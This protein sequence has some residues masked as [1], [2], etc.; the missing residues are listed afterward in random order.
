MSSVEIVKLIAGQFEGGFQRTATGAV[1]QDLRYRA[2]FST[3]NSALSFGVMQ[4]DIG[5]HGGAGDQAFRKILG[6]ATAAGALTNV[7]ADTL[8]KKAAVPGANGTNL[9]ASEKAQLDTI[10]GASYAKPVIDQFDN[11]EAAK[12]WQRLETGSEQWSSAWTSRGYTVLAA[13]SPADPGYYDLL[14][15]VAATLNKRPS[16][17]DDIDRL[18]S[19][20]PLTL[21][22]GKTLQLTRPPTADDLYAAFDQL[23]V[24]NGSRGGVNGKIENLRERLQPVPN[25]IRLE[26]LGT[27]RR[28]GALLFDPSGTGPGYAFDATSPASWIMT[29][30]GGGATAQRLLLIDGQLYVADGASGFPRLFG[31]S[32]DILREIAVTGPDW[33]V[34]NGYSLDYDFASSELVAVPATPTIALTSTGSR[35]SIKI[36]PGREGGSLVSPIYDPT[37][38]VALPKGVFLKDGVLS[39]AS[40]RFVQLDVAPDLN[41]DHVAV[42]HAFSGNGKLEVATTLAADGSVVD[43]KVGLTAVGETS[44]MSFGSGGAAIGSILGSY[45]AGDNQIAAIAS[46]VITAQV[47]QAI[48]TSLGGVFAG[49][50][51]SQA[52]KTAAT[53][54]P[55]DLAVAGIGAVSS[56]LTAELIHAVGLNGVAAELANTV[57]SVV[58]TQIVTN[59]VTKGAAN[60]FDAL[61]GTALATA[62]GSY[63]GNKLASALVKFDTIGGQLGSAIGSSVAVIAGLAILG[64]PAGWTA[65]AVAAAASFIGNLFGGPI[66]SIFGGTPR[67]GADVTWDPET[68]TFAATN[69]WSRKGGSQDAARG[70]AASVAAT[71]NNILGTIGGTLLN[72]TAVQ[73]GNY[74]LRKSEYVYRPV[75]SQDTS[76]ITR[77]FKGKNGSSDLINYG[78]GQALAGTGFAIAGG[79]VI[80]KRALYASTAL[81]GSGFAVD[82]LLGDLATAQHYETYLAN[83]TAI[84]ALISAEPG[85]VFTAEQAIILARAVELGLTRRAASDWFGGFGFLLN[86]LATVPSLADFRFEFDPASGRIAR[87]ID[88]G[89]YTMGDTIDVAGQTVIQGTAGNDDIRLTA[90]QLAATNAGANINVGLIVDDV[91]FNGAAKDLLVAAIVDAGAGDDRVQASDRGDNVFGGAGNDTLLGGKLDDWLIGGDGNDRL[92]AGTVTTTAF[93]DGALPAINSVIASDGGSGNYLDGGVG[94]DRLYGGSGS[95]WL[96][97]G[98]NVDL[99]YGGAGGDIIDGGTGNDQ[100]SALN[101]PALFGG[102]GSDQYVYNRGDGSD[103]IFDSANPAAAAGDNDTLSISGDSIAKRLADIQGGASRNWAGGGDF[104]IDGSVTGGEDAIV[105]GTGITMADILLE[106]GGDQTNGANN[107]LKIKVLDPVTG[108]WNLTDQILVRDWFESTRR[109]EWLRFANGDELRIGDLTTFKIGTAAADVLIG[110]N[111]ADFLYG[112][113]GDDV[114][115]GLKG[116]DFGDGGLGD[117]LVS[118]DDD[119]DIVLGGQGK[120]IVLGGKG[121]DV[122]S[123]DAGDDKLYGGDGGDVVVGGKGDDELIGGAGDDIFKIDRGDG[124]DLLFDELASGWELVWNGDYTNGYAQQTDGTVAKGGV[125]YFDGKTW[126]GRYNYDQGQGSA[127]TIRELYRYVGSGA[128]VNAGSDTLEFGVGID[129]QDLL[130]RKNGNDLEIA[131]TPSGAATD[132][133][134]AVANRVTIQD[135]Y[136]APTI[137][138]FQFVATGALSVASNGQALIQLVAGTDADDSALSATGNTSGAWITGGGGADTISG[139]GQYD[140]LNGGSGSDAL[141]AGAGLDVLYGG[142]GN[143]TLDGGAGAD[144]L[145]GGSGSDTASYASSTAGLTVFI[146]EALRAYRSKDAQD[147]AYTGIENLM[148]SGYADALY[149]DSGDNVLD[150]GTGADTLYGGEGDDSY[151]L[152]FGTG[153]DTIIEGKALPDFV[154]DKDGKID[155][156]RYTPV[157]SLAGIQSG[158]YQYQLR[159]A[160][161]SDGLVAYDTGKVLDSATVYKYNAAKPV[162]PYFSNGVWDTTVAGFTDTSWKSGYARAPN[163]KSVLAT[164]ILGNGGALDVLEIGTDNS[165]VPRGL[166]LSNLSASKAGNSLTIV[167][168]ASDKA[169]IQ[170]FYLSDDN[171]VET[172]QF[173]DGLAVDLTK[174]RLGLAVDSGT[175]GDDLIF[176]TS[177]ADSL[178]GNLGNDVLS[179]GVGADTLSGGAGDDVL[180]GGGQADALDGGSDTETDGGLLD[181]AKPYGDTIRYVGSSALVNVDL[182][183]A[184]AQIGGDAAGDLI[185]FASGVS[186]IENITG[187]DGYGDTLTGDAR[188]NRLFGLGGNDSIVGGGGDDV[189]A[190]GVGNDTL[191]GEAGNDNISGDDGDDTIDGGSGNDVIA[192]GLGL[193]AIAGGTG[194][195]TI[196]GGNDNDTSLHGNDGNDG[197]GGGAGNDAVFGDAGNDQLDGGSGNDTLWGGLDNDTL[198]G[199]AGDDVLYGEAGDDAYA[200]D[201]NSGSDTIVDAAGANRIL[202]SSVAYD[203]LWLVKSGNDLRISVIGGSSSVTV[204]DYFAVTS[205]TLVRE[206]ATATHSLF[207]KYAGGQSYAGSLIEAM[208]LAGASAPAAMPAAIAARLG[209]FWWAGGKA[210]PAVM[211]QALNVAEDAALVGQVGAVDHDENIASYTLVTPPLHGGAPVIAANG[212]WSYTPTAN[213]NGPDSFQIKVRDADGNEALQ[214]VNV[215]VTPVNDLP[216]ITTA[217]NALAVDENAA[218]NSVIGTLAVTDV[219]GDLLAWSLTDDAGGRFL[220]SSAGVLSVRDGSLLNRETAVSHSITVQVS[221]GVGAPVAKTM[222]IG[223]NDVNERPGT[224]LQTGQP[225]VRANESFGGVSAALAGKTVATLSVSD[226]DAGQTPVLRL[227]AGD[228][229]VFAISGGNL[230]FASGFNPDFE[231]LALLPGTTLVDRD[232]N[233]RKEVELTASVGGFDGTLASLGTVSVTVGI[234]DVNEAPTAIALAGSLT[235]AERDH[236]AAGDPLLAA[237]LGT[238]STTDPDL[239]SLEGFAYT[240]SDSAAGDMFEVSGN[241]LRLKAG[242]SLDYET[243]A[244]DGTNRYVD[245]TVTS[246]DRN[247][248]TGSLAYAKTFHVLLSDQ[249]D[250]TYGTSGNDAGATKLVGAAGADVIFGYVGADQLYGGNGNDD[251][252]G[253]DGN[254]YLYGENGDDTVRGEAGNDWLYGS[255]GDDQLFGG[256]GDDIVQGDAGN[257]TMSGDDG[258][259]TLKG[260]TGN[261]TL[262]GGAGNDLLYGGSG[263]NT[264]GGGDG[265][266]LL[267]GGVNGDAFD[268]GLGSDT[269]SYAWTDL[270]IAATTGVTVNVTAPGSNLGVA[271]GDSYTAIERIDATDFADT[272]TGSAASETLNGLGDID[273]IDGGGGDDVIDGG[274]GND[275]LRGSSGNDSIFGSTGLDTLYGDAGFDTLDGGD[276]ND[277]LHGGD[278]GDVLKGGLGNDTLYGEG[279][280]DIFSFARGDGD[281]VVDQTGALAGDIDVLGFTGGIANTNLWFET[282]GRDVKVSVLGASGYDGSVRLKDH[283]DLS[284]HLTKVSYVTAGK[285]VTVDLGIQALAATLDQFAAALGYK[286]STQSQFDALMANTTLLVAGKTFKQHWDNYWTG[287]K[288]PAFTLTNAPAFSAGWAEDQYSGSGFALS[289][290][291]ADDLTA[292]PSLQ[293]TAMLVTGNGSTTPTAA[294]LGG[295]TAAWPTDGTSTGTITLKTNANTSGSGWLWLHAVDAGGVEANEWLPF[296][297]TAVA[298]APLITAAA[299]PGGNAGA[300][301][302]LNI[303]ALLT[304]TDGSEVIDRIEISG[305]PAGFDFASADH[306]VSAGNNALG[307]A[308][309]RFSTAQLSGLTLTAPAG[310]SADLTGAAALQVRAFSV[311][312][313]NGSQAASSSSTPLAVRINAPPTDVVFTGSVDENAAPGTVI[314]VVTVTDPDGTE[315][316]RLDLTPWS[317]NAALTTAGWKLN[318]S[319]ETQ[320]FATTGPLGGTVTALRTGQFD[321]GVAGGGVE[322]SAKVTIDPN[323]AYKFSV[324]FRAE[325]LTK[326]TL[327]FGLSGGSPAYV[328]NGGTGAD[329]GNPY[330]FGI[331]PPQEQALFQTGVWY[332]ADGVVLPRGHQL[333]GNG[334]FGGIFNAATGVRLSNADTQVYRWNDTMPDTQVATRFFSYYNE[335]QSGWSHDWY[336]PTITE[337]PSLTLADTRG[338]RLAIDSRSGLI[339]VGSTAIDYEDT[340]QLPAGDKAFHPQ[341]T[342]TDSGGL[343]LTKAINVTVNNVNELPFAPTGPAQAY[344]DETWL[345]SNPA[346][347]GTVLASFALADPDGTTPVLTFNDSA[348]SNGWYDLSGGQVRL[349][350]GVSF[351]FEWFKANGSTFRDFNSDGREEVLVD[352]F[353]LRAKDATDLSAASTRFQLFIQNTNETPNAPGL[354]TYTP[355]FAETLSGDTAHANQTIATFALSDPDQVTPKLELLTNPNGWFSTVGNALVFSG[356]VNF[357]ADWMRTYSGPYGGG[358]DL[359]GDGLYESKVSTVLV[360]AKDTSGLISGGVPVDVYIEDVNERPSFGSPSYGAS[361]AENAAPQ[362]IATVT[363]IDPDQG[364]TGSKQFYFV[365]AGGSTVGSIDGTF[366]VAGTTADGRFAIDAASGAIRSTV[367]FDY[368]TNPG[369]FDYTVLTRDATSSPRVATAPLHVSPQDVNEAPSIAPGQSFSVA[370]NALG[371][372]STLVGTL[373]AND[374]DTAAAN[375]NLKYAITSG[376]TGNMFLI[377]SAGEIRLNASP[378]YE[379]QTSYTLGVSVIDQGG[380][381]LSA[382][383]A[384]T[385]TINPVNEAPKLST[386]ISVMTTSNSYATQLLGSVAASDPEGDV[387]SVTKTGNS[388][389]DFIRVNASGQ[390][391]VAYKPYSYY[392][393]S[394]SFTVT[395]R[396]TSTPEHYQTTNTINWTYNYTGSFSPIVLDL[397]GDGVT[398]TSV[399]SSPVRFDVNDDGVTDQAGWAGPG[400]G[401]LALDRN[402]SGAIDRFDEI[403]F[404]ADVDN[405]I[406]DLE[407]LRAFD[408][409][410]NGFFDV[411]DAMFG[412][413]QIWQDANQDGVSQ[414]DELTTLAERHIQAI[415][416]TLTPTGQVVEGATDN[417]IYATTE[418]VRDNGTT[419]DVGDVFFAYYPSQ[420]AQPAAGYQAMSTSESK[421]IGTAARG[422]ALLPKGV[423]KPPQKI[424]FSGLDPNAPV[425]DALKRSAPTIARGTAGLVSSATKPGNLAAI[426]QRSTVAGNDPTLYVGLSA[427]Q[428]AQLKAMPDS[429]KSAQSTVTAIS[430]PQSKSPQPARAPVLPARAATPPSD[431]P[432]ATPA[433]A[434]K[435]TA[436][437]AEA[438]TSPTASAASPTPRDTV[439][440]MSLAGATDPNVP[441]SGTANVATAPLIADAARIDP[442]VAAIAILGSASASDQIRIAAPPALVGAARPSSRPVTPSALGAATASSALV[443]TQL[444]KLLAAMAAFQGGAGVGAVE[445]RLTS[446][447]AVR[448]LVELAGGY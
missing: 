189:L 165:A 352:D 346:N 228:P 3:A 272:I 55:A 306:T 183:R 201:A 152:G 181:P 361:I 318:A 195:D 237:P 394:G 398:L 254:D 413:F 365:N 264:L 353:Y 150:G 157:W 425:P 267:V 49:L 174:I 12:L 197:V 16:S 411:G 260:G 297:V 164:S 216:V 203:R 376:N 18:L 369:G 161:N 313:S 279:G 426:T 328:E 334:V 340:A 277:I 416:L 265:D 202:F 145:V 234:E 21:T 7:Q 380:A 300:A 296:S 333:V 37:T 418:F 199:G 72:P 172:L 208:T 238:L 290:K 101:A 77:S 89:N 52:V 205:P 325:D 125:T 419:G 363:S 110:T 143:D 57:G 366:Q 74:G 105:F 323:K 180:E 46:S 307:G 437:N 64:G 9:T 62:V 95:D 298:D 53:H 69:A 239:A 87:A 339:T 206:I 24:W 20:K 217:T 219:D 204:K 111:G 421:D 355:R 236:P 436:S 420:A 281:D 292:T 139:T 335:G 247:F 407:G 316:S 147:D 249:V 141:S 230:V 405:A 440:A 275:T 409:N 351:D 442:L 226:V 26:G 85:S 54:I 414:A 119:N 331:M 288:A 102:G 408:S 194:D 256:L 140:I 120:D 168:S 257:D 5:T 151:V 124:R 349:K 304:D 117:D 220:L 348:T 14:G 244:F 221:D 391:Y 6:L 36:Y 129:I 106:R 356:G 132:N 396:E 266:D 56:Y 233:G 171:K 371:F 48:G 78:V 211:A 245:V 377:N 444:Q 148:G 227:A 235:L 63:V 149:G 47:G 302:A 207:P 79:D 190:G 434:A 159:I 342:A 422:G 25:L 367:A 113:G 294:P 192:G 446:D 412:Q 321:S 61:G 393:M 103:V 93:A 136:A 274:N 276:G 395:A 90:M 2:T 250:Y 128:A 301:I 92:F 344:F 191:L 404:A 336:Q 232:G 443:E 155:L 372:G 154:T 200:F 22:S 131:L 295:L 162:S 222:T 27:L 311:E 215:T 270:G 11:R 83:A 326:H 368:E 262:A 96:K 286:P 401:L 223:V 273:N 65:L 282:S 44:L 51:V 107:D 187:S 80:L 258:I 212:S 19:G 430:A 4:L 379:Q 387:L 224:P 246:H 375:R 43:T 34:S 173:R 424:A 386:P 337:L 319:V 31:A 104:T 40:G 186:T 73:A 252:Y 1:V 135:W 354:I 130:F 381:G 400:D 435:H 33:M 303:T 447:S 242:R 97:G 82:A 389:D 15:I 184:T 432:V 156:T 284:S 126:A 30:P 305:V 240:V 362:A 283:L 58:I 345:G 271:A 167:Y 253:G 229:A 116:D 287:N 188:A 312:S 32:A 410:E 158:F 255:I 210:V 137:E 8:R 91:A 94:D 350:P 28:E 231:T 144:I 127:P 213:F 423:L 358:T 269:V 417:V 100:G 29:A 315:A 70:L 384:V 332:R 329:D 341:V 289:L 175:P 399:A 338:S 153:A 382:T 66:G 68:L 50:S 373:I 114:I 268:G 170:D 185:V 428:I 285:T 322:A 263:T 45:L 248:G 406:S 17:F 214:T 327:F 39:D 160:R 320:L 259:D 225:I 343:T 261:D 198:T 196:D 88:I 41:G 81:A 251:L 146:D 176:G 415:N 86:S 218:N 99:I 439:S 10:L 278:D 293:P 42:V 178:A 98:D 71:Y 324:Y 330:F 383:G 433:M 122:L 38:G 299:S 378:D 370:E 166:S 109:V 403:S 314:G 134:A 397:D 291:L 347:P 445:G 112:S 402:G 390:I 35:L 309:W 59:I 138:S 177:S 357:T 392:F 84:N 193:D 179:G 60:A 123:G 169:T 385:V 448:P 108:K 13:L 209:E 310:W 374:P 441:P 142:D 67:S 121:N 75:S 308:L 163:S 118:G 182:N 76:A 241:V 133:F 364:N 317:D 427:E 388:S 438:T 243:A 359:D 23:T 280:N 115:F 360:G 429:G 431:E